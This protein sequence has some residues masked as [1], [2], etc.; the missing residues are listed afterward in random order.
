MRLEPFHHGREVGRRGDEVKVI[1][2]DDVTEE[3]KGI[4][5][6]RVF[7]AFQYDPDRL[8]PRED[9]QPTG[10]R[11]RLEVRRLGLEVALA[12]SRHDR[13]NKP[14]VPIGYQAKL[15]S[16]RTMTFAT[17]V[18]NED[19]GNEDKCFGLHISVITSR[20]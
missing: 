5:R 7:P 14:C 20:R 2:K 17:C 18:P 9:R 16:S 8:G 6:M 10:D 12:A 3:A 4:V 15:N 11:T 1:L 13:Y 19:V